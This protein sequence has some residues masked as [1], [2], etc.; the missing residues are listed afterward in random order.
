[1]APR[2]GSAPATGMFGHLVQTATLPG[3]WVLHRGI[4]DR[5]PMDFPQITRGRV[6]LARAATGD[7]VAWE[8]EAHETVADGLGRA[9]GAKKTVTRPSVRGAPVGVMVAAAYNHDNTQP[10]SRLQSR[11]AST[12]V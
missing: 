9:A 10:T 11:S 1:M 5:C 2:R 12:P 3:P 8:G 6:L 4:Y 7:Q